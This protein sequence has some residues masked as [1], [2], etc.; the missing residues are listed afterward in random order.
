MAKAQDSRNKP[1]CCWKQTALSINQGLSIILCS[2]T[3][4]ND[5]HGKQPMKASQG[6]DDTPPFV[7]NV[8]AL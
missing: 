2:A 7:A 3:V 8:T 4:L 5:S 6:S 1:K